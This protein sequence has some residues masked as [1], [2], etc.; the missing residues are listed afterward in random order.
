M[1]SKNTGSWIKRNGGQ[2]VMLMSYLLMALGCG[3]IT[4]RTMDG[5]DG[6]FVQMLML[7]L[8]GVYG[9]LLIHIV[10]HEAGHMIFGMLTGYKFRSF[11]VASFVWQRTAEGKVRFGVSPLPGAA[12]QCLMSPPEM[13][14]GTMPFFWYNL[15]GALMNIVISLVCLMAMIFVSQPVAYAL[16]AMCALVG[17]VTAATNGVPMRVGAVDNDGYNILSMRRSPEAVRSLW[18][19]LKV[20][21]QNA[22]G[23]RLRD[24]PEEWFSMP[25]RAAMKNS[26][27]A[28]VGVFR[29]GRLLDQMRIEEALIAMQSMMRQGAGMAGLHRASMKMDMACCELLLDR[30]REAAEK[31][32]DQNTRKLMRAMKNHLSA[33]RTEYLLALLG[34]GDERKAE[35]ILARFEKAAEKWPSAAD[36]ESE[37]EMIGRANELHALK[38]E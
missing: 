19:Q 2:I 8:V 4:A 30:G 27:C 6:S 22:Q 9:S 21:G 33:I 26:L 3:I 5:I 18:V 13:K 35:E 28:A 38:N 34:E 14:D 29:C 20:A 24:M 17:L 11:R 37:R 15:G 1:K 23:V 31:T 36:V 10:L 12:G 7:V 16:L 32:L 25:S